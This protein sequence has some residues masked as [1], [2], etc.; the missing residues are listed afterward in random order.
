MPSKGPDPFC[1]GLPV[2]RTVNRPSQHSV[3]PGI[4][5]WRGVACWATFLIAPLGWFCSGRLIRR[6]EPERLEHGLVM[7]LP[8]IE[9]HSFLNVAVL[10]GLIDGGVRSA[11]EIVDWTTGNRIL[12]L[13]H[14]RGWKRNNR[15]AHDLAARIVAYQNQYPGR[16]V[17][18]V[19]HSGGG[20]MALLTAAALPAGHQLTGVVMLATAVSPV[21]DLRRAL[22][23]VKTSIWSHYSWFDALFLLLGTTMVGTFDGRH[24][25]AA[26]AVGFRGPQIDDEMASGRLIQIRW[27]W[28]MLFQ[29]NFGE[30]F[31]CVHR[32]YIADEVAPLIVASEADS[33]D[34]HGR[35]Q[36]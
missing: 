2:M 31:G 18:V 12:F 23:G 26:G 10:A 20:G 7:I 11:A 17:W 28:R 14:L 9:G 3:S 8:G 25:F 19:G 6:M 29:F 36:E 30:H 4:R 24:G 16:P 1:R 35:C 22:A 13:F 33:A 5:L 15:V 32:V 21:F 34:E 27:N